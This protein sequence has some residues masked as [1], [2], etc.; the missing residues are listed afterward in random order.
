MLFRSGWNGGPVDRQVGQL[1]A[2][3]VTAAIA[4]GLAGQG[5]IVPDEHKGK[6]LSGKLFAYTVDNK[7]GWT[8]ADNTVM[9][10]TAPTS[11]VPT[12]TPTGPT[13]AQYDAVVAERDGLKGKIA[14][15]I[16]TLS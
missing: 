2:P 9:V 7:S 3:G 10:G 5:I 11:P 12:P 15:A 1:Y 8:G 6:V 4:S 14:A 13:Q 16:V